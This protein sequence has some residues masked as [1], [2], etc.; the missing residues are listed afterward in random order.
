MVLCELYIE[1]ASCPLSGEERYPLAGGLLII[2]SMVKSIGESAAVRYKVGV[3]CW[4]VGGSTVVKQQPTLGT[5]NPCLRRP[6]SLQPLTTILE[7]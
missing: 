6:S 4:L 2:I 5:R 1:V 3:R 7:A